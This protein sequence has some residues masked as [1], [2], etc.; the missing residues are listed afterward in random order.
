MIEYLLGNVIHSQDF[1]SEN[2]AKVQT[3]LAYY[4][5]EYYRAFL[6][7]SLRKGVWDNNI[8]TIVSDLIDNYAT[9]NTI[10]DQDGNINRYVESILWKQGGSY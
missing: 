5:H 3:S 10:Y 6:D 2:I 1:I 7:G 9:E 8:P 4:N